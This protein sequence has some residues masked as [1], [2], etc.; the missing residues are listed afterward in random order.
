MICPGAVEAARAQLRRGA[1]YRPD[2]TGMAAAAELAL[3]TPRAGERARLPGC[4]PLPTAI[5]LHDFEG[6]STQ[7]AG[8]IADVSQATFKSPRH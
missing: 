4:D 2:G 7:Q 5:V 8:E 3:T 6:F 1:L